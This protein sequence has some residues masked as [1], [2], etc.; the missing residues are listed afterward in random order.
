MGHARDGRTTG[1]ENVGA[2]S[3]DDEHVHDFL[4]NEREEGKQRA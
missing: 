2:S 4:C 3:M 1:L